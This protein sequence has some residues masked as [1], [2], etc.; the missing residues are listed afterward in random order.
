MTIKGGL[1]RKLNGKKM[2]FSGERE[3]QAGDGE[4]NAQS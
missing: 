3:N 4:K 1:P 2:K